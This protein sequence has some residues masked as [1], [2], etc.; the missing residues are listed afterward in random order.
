MQRRSGWQWF[1]DIR[2]AQKLYFTVGIMAT[3][4]A[5]ELVTLWFAIGTLSSVRAYVEG[6]GLW[7]KGQKDGVY[8]LQKYSY[9]HNE[10][11]YQ[12]FLTFMKVPLGD[13]KAREALLKQPP[14][15]EGARQGFLEG[16]NHPE[17][18]DGMCH[19][20]LRFHDI[21]Y[22][23][24]AIEIWAEADPDIIGLLPT[25]EALHAQITSAAPDEKVI[26]SLRTK[27]QMTNEKLTV[28]EDN[29]SYALGEGSRWL[30]N[31]VLKLLFA[32]ALTVE[33][34][35]LL[36]AFSVSRGI[37]RGLDEIIRASDAIANGETDARAEIYSRDEIGML[38][39]S[40]NNM[41]DELSKA[42]GKFRKLLESAPDAMVIVNREGLIRLVN[43]QTE[44]IF[45]F[46]REEL[47]GKPVEILIPGE[48]SK[49]HSAHRESFFGDP[50][51]RS[52]GMGLELYGQRK[53]GEKFPVEI[54]LS[55]LET[56]EGLWVSA[57][58]RDISEKKLDHEAL[59]DYA[60]KLEISNNNLEQFAYVASHDLQE[61]LRTITNFAHE[62]HDKEIGRLDEESEVYMDYIVSAS[63]R[64]KVLIRDLLMYSRIGKKRVIELIDCGQV[65][66]DAQTDLDVL[67]RENNAK[68]I[69]HPLPKIRGSKTEMVQLFQNLIGNAVKYRKPDV[70]PEVEIAAE[71]DGGYWIFMVKDN[72]IGIDKEFFSRIFVIFQR[73]HTQNQYSGTGIGL[74]TCKKIVEMNGGKI[75]V[76]S[77]PGQGSVFYFKLPS[78]MTL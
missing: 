35:G 15:L 56:E 22:L 21:Y 14:D 25:G 41:A 53:N 18:I 5:V 57:A 73:L 70:P 24:K 16:R 1:R 54:S 72:G 52:M 8:H 63:E 37:Q 40:I 7:S 4:I 29:F 10:A 50:K 45:Q 26:D 77:E 3:L 59:R 51:I 78:V 34:S 61:P 30:E 48:F 58:I 47:I 20:V 71:E 13:H 19:L 55:P 38:A 60:R 76:K 17:D 68:I 74:A 49:N 33:I 12:S 2:I 39:T 11:D 27:V 28:L 69:I 62:L 31:I 32:V 43:A 9:S 67:I 36:L 65:V 42:E 6:E 75:W 23:H 44:K 64:M 46:N 66:Q